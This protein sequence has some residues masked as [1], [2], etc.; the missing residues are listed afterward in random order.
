MQA[1]IQA[2]VRHGG[3]VSYDLHMV[4]ISFAPWMPTMFETPYV[5]SHLPTEEAPDDLSVIYDDVRY[6][7]YQRPFLRVEF[8]SE[9]QAQAMHD[10]FKRHPVNRYRVELKIKSPNSSMVVFRRSK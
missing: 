2:I 10:Y 1:S 9:Q 5:K 6:L 4:A 7:A 3:A 8:A